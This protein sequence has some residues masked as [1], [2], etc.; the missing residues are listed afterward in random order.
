MT[1]QALVLE[2]QREALTQHRLIKVKLYG[3]MLA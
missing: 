2:S 1:S 3:L